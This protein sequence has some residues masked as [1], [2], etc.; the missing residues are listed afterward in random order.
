M[1]KLQHYSTLIPGELAA[2]GNLLHA[3]DLLQT[4]DS[5]PEVKNNSLICK[6]LSFL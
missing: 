6:R 3:D 4:A 2:T 5:R 1:L